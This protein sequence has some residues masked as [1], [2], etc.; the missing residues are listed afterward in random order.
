MGDNKWYLTVTYDE[1]K[2]IIR[3][4]LSI[5]SRSFIAI[6]YYL[7]HIRD[8]EMYRQDGFENIWEFAESNYGI[9]R[10]TAKRWMDINT[11]FSVDGNT[12]ILAERYRNFGKSQMQEMLYLDDKQIE[13]VTSEMTVKEIRDIR[14]PDVEEVQE[15]PV[16]IL[17][18]PL[19]VYPQ[20]SLL[21]TPGCGNQD[22]FQCHRDGCELRQEDCYC[23]KAPLGNPFPC[24][25]IN[26]VNMLREEIGNSCQFVNEDLANHRS[27]GQP[28]PCCNA[29]DKKSICGYACSRSNR[30]EHKKV[31]REEQN[32]AVETTC[33]VAQD[34]QLPVICPEDDEKSI[35]ELDLSVRTYNCLKRADVDTIEQLRNMSDEELAKV[36]NFGK[37]N[38][39]EVHQKLEEYDAAA[40][41]ECATSHTEKDVTEKTEI[42]LE[43]SDSVIEE[44]KIVTKQEDCIEE[45]TEETTEDSDIQI[46]KKTLEKE[47]RMLCDMKECYT[48]NDWRVRRQK[49]L[50][51][52]L[53]NFLYELEELN[54]EQEAEQPEFPVL[55]NNDQRKEFIDNYMNWPLWLETKETGERYYR[56]E[57]DNGTAFVVKVYYHRCFDYAA[58]TDNFEDRYSNRYGSEEYY[59]LIDGKFFK[60]CLTNKTALV[61]HLKEVQKH[62]R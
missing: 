22:C 33:D 49:L 19:R 1:A 47:N 25:T 54:E 44:Q 30:E 12:P 41:E 48:E 59:L 21:T 45:L 18:Y 11:R 7:K 61:E 28:V 3:D 56:Y 62:G 42:V 43:N 39:D 51:G 17:G 23:V 36:R 46:V 5:M 4:N 31:I 9:K 8:N 50:V 35:D 10:S 52:A 29:C 58:V 55:K 16:S 20:G 2:N 38:M 37:V 57:F 13:E 32:V 27:D 60:D 6:W 40:V 53:A 24:T 14:K 34:E 26:V 15:E